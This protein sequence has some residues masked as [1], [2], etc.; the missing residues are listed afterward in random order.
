MCLWNKIRRAKYLLWVWGSS[1]RIGPVKVKQ[2]QW[3]IDKLHLCWFWSKMSIDIFYVLLANTESSSHSKNKALFF[4]YL[5]LFE[6]L[7]YC[8]FVCCKLRFST[9]CTGNVLNDLLL[10]EV[11]YLLGQRPNRS[12]QDTVSLLRHSWQQGNH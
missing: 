1:K 4:C 9:L 12:P 10:V 6:Y 8:L 11:G 7:P 5:S 3:L 2:S